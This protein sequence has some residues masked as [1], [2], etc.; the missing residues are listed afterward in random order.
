MAQ[1][2]GLP[3]ETFSKW[4]RATR[5]RLQLEGCWNTVQARDDDQPQATVDIAIHNALKRRGNSLLRLDAE[6]AEQALDSWDEPTRTTFRVPALDYQLPESDTDQDSTAAQPSESPQVLEDSPDEQP[7]EKAPRRSRPE[8]SAAVGSQR[9]A[10][11]H[12]AAAASAEQ[13]DVLGECVILPNDDAGPSSSN[14]QFEQPVCRAAQ[15]IA[16][17]VARLQDQRRV[18]LCSNDQAA[19]ASDDNM[20]HQPTP[21][22]IAPRPSLPSQQQFLLMLNRNTSAAMDIMNEQ[23]AYFEQASTTRDNWIA[24]HIQLCNEQHLRMQQRAAQ[25]LVINQLRQDLQQSQ[26]VAEQARSM[27]TSLIDQAPSSPPQQQAEQENSDLKAKLGWL[28]PNQPNNNNNK[29]DDDD[30]DDSAPP[31]M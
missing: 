11:E 1:D 20:E 31:L 4:Q 18:L 9:I 24:Q 28:T 10:D 14:I 23:I 17:G 27:L 16:D 5:N 7:P 22:L 6:S 12:A 25:Q 21:P 8:P 30:D 15:D 19:S 2:L 26:N 29:D 13:S 3:S